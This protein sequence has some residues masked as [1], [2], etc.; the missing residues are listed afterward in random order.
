M[1]NYRNVFRP[2]PIFA[3]SLGLGLCLGQVGYPW[4]GSNA[5]PPA[6]AP[7]IIQTFNVEAPP[8]YGGEEVP[9]L[10]PPGGDGGFVENF[11]NGPVY[12]SSF[13][14]PMPQT[15]VEPAFNAAA[16]APRPNIPYN[17]QSGDYFS[18]QGENQPVWSE[19]PLKVYIE[20]SERVS[21]DASSSL[22]WAIDEWKRYFP[23]EIT[24][25]KSLAHIRVEWV[26]EVRGKGHSRLSETQV[27]S[28]A[29]GEGGEDKQVLKRVKVQLVKPERYDGLAD[30]AMRGVILHEL[31]HAL[32]IRRDSDVD[33]DVMAEPEVDS[34][35]GKAIQEAVK[36]LAMKGL[37]LALSTQGITWGLGR[38]NTKTIEPKVRV[39]ETIS[40]RDL[41]TLYRLYGI[42]DNATA[43]SDPFGTYPPPF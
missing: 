18:L 32:G 41:N 25:E 11:D 16:N 40:Q 31:G 9:M 17:G 42:Q 2:A 5:Y 12:T 10:L 30:R 29:A 24:R 21:D 36:S 4:A 23:M 27:L 8:F 3:L 13:N 28:T 15:F 20:E 35:K 33:G 43:H 22:K 39:V 14:A 19:F 34:R 1:Q 37:D 6:D 7:E 26:N 38:N